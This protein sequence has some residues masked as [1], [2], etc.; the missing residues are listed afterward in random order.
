M[1]R[2]SGSRKAGGRGSAVREPVEQGTDDE[3]AGPTSVPL[4]AAGLQLEAAEHAA[5][6]GDHNGARALAA[7]ARSLAH[8][9]GNSAVETRASVFLS[10]LGVD[11][12][13]LCIALATTIVL[14]VV[15]VRTLSGAG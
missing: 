10:Q 12:F 14:V 4:D 1:S 13:A 2:R 11:P 5:V 8:S 3:V 9:A 15:T 6:R 7:E